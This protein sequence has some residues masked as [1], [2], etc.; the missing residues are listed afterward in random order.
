VQP[1]QSIPP[2]YRLLRSFDLSQEIRILIL[3]NIAGLI[4]FAVFGALFF[5][6][7]IRTRPE[8]ARGLFGGSGGLWQWLLF[9][10]D[11]LAAYAAVLF[12]HEVV[13]GICFWIFTRS[14]PKFGLRSAYAFAAAPDWFIPRNQYLIIGLAPLIVITIAGIAVLHFL[15]GAALLPWWVAVT[16]NASGAVGDL[17]IVGW[18]FRQSS[19]TLINDFGDRLAIYVPA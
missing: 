2:D 13:H 1:V 19:R 3:L 18:L 15:P 14:A 11:L 16:G 8:S 12:L 9:I 4:L 5:L 6:L 7:I 10:L 17:F